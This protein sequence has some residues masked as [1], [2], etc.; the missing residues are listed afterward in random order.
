MIS[1]H[2]PDTVRTRGIGRAPCSSLL[3]RVVIGPLRHRGKDHHAIVRP[4]LL[5]NMANSRAQADQS[6]EHRDREAAVVGH[7]A[8]AIRPPGR[9][10]APPGL[11]RPVT[12]HEVPRSPERSDAGV[13]DERREL[14]ILEVAREPLPHLAELA[15]D[16]ANLRVLVGRRV[17]LIP[18]HGSAPFQLHLIADAQ[19]AP[20]PPVASLR[21]LGRRDVLTHHPLPPGHQPTPRLPRRRGS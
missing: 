12:R 21:P 16:H 5:I 8:D 4:L 18:A 2:C 15:D 3:L 9:V 1:G 6:L 11:E 7:L 19:R 13:F 17:A 14:R 10:E 20:G